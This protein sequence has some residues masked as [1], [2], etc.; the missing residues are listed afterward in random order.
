[1]LVTNLSTSFATGKAGLTKLV[2][3]SERPFLRSFSAMAVRSKSTV[4]DMTASSRP[5]CFIRT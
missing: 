4:S 2:T 3:S 1:M 5:K